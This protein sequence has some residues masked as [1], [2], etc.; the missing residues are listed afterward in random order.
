MCVDHIPSPVDN[1]KKKVEHIYT[2]PLDSDL[3]EEMVLCEA[4]VCGSFSE[5]NFFFVF[6]SVIST[7]N[8][9]WDFFFCR[10]WSNKIFR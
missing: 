2:G 1:A 9:T 3:A 6:D 5:S 4:E 7:F 8:Y 10:V